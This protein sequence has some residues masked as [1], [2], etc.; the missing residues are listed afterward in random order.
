MTTKY[1]YRQNVF[2]NVWIEQGLGIR[3][4]G[5]TIIDNLANLQSIQ[6]Q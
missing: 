2:E 1:Y 5:K 3:F 4:A 6:K